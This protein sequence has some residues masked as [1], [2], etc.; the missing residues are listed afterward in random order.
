VRRGVLYTVG[1]SNR[2]LAELI[3]IMRAHRID[4]LVDVR[5]IR[6]SRRNPQFEEASLAEGLSDCGIVYAPLP[7]LGGMRR[8]RPDSHHRGLADDG[9]RGYADHMETP[10]FESGLRALFD[11]AA[12]RRT[13]V[14][15]AEA[16]YRR[17]HRSLLSDAATVR[18]WEVVHLI[19]SERSE[20]HRMSAAARSDDGRLSYPAVQRELFHG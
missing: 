8:P 4:D 6:R 11:R 9:M 15:C 18:Q 5:T 3:A 19:D 2:S 17:C 14:M 13:A 20:P 7:A 16:D 10:Q 1:H 12:R